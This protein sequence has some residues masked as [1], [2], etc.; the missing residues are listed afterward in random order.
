MGHD[1]KIVKKEAD[2]WESL[3]SG[4]IIERASY[5]SRTNNLNFAILVTML[6]G[7]KF[8]DEYVTEDFADVQELIDQL[9]EKIQAKGW[10]G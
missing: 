1:Y 10:V 9:R 6:A 7:T 2:D 5:Y 3:D 4:E 8:D